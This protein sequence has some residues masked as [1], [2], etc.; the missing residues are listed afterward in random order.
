MF[1]WP[2][3][4]EHVIC[5]MISLNPVFINPNWPSVSLRPRGAP[6]QGPF[7][8]CGQIKICHFSLGKTHPDGDTCVHT[9]HACE[10]AH[11]RM[12]KDTRVARLRVSMRTAWKPSLSRSVLSGQKPRDVGDRDADP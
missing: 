10:S 5:K 9:Y 6:L 12:C 2:S 7:S 11:V 4:K 8:F 3:A 1:G